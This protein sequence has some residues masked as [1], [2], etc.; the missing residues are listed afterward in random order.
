MRRYATK[1]TSKAYAV[2]NSELPFHEIASRRY[3]HCSA[4]CLV[5]RIKSALEFGSIVACCVALGAECADVQGIR[6]SSLIAL[7]VALGSKCNFWP[8]QESHRTGGTQ[9]KKIPPRRISSIAKCHSC[10][11]NW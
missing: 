7:G 4:S 9:G 5:R 2:G 6:S 3:I 10:S 8:S 11:S 1:G